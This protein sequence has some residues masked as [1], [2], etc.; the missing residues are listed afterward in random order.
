[1]DEKYF[2][3][4][5]LKQPRRGLRAQILAT[6][7]AAVESPT[8]TDRIW[9]SRPLRWAACALFI[10]TLVFNLVVVQPQQT[11][12]IQLSTNE[13]PPKE[14]RQEKQLREFIEGLNG[15]G[16]YLMAQLHL[17]QTRTTP[18]EQY[19]KMRNNANRI[20]NESM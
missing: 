5:Q 14:T 3:K 18:V 7:Q 15:D 6:A 11:N 17:M 16:K 9:Q 20:L 10:L 1:M 2:N 19:I 8:L 13:Q 12:L 4:F